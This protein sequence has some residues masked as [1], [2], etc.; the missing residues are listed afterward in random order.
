MNYRKKERGNKAN[1]VSYRDV[2]RTFCLYHVIRECKLVR[3]Y[4]GA[5]LSYTPAPAS[6]AP[7]I[8][9][10][11]KRAG[12]VFRLVVL[13]LEEVSQLWRMYIHAEL[14]VRGLFHLVVFFLVL[15]ICT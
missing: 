4:K 9:G 11:M 12:R 13:Y 10:G 15:R 3:A 7:S 1:T 8:H 5:F 6:G 14:F 2:T